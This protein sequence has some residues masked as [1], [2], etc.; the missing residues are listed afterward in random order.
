MA[1]GSAEQENNGGGGRGSGE[2]RAAARGS[3]FPQKEHIISSRNQSRTKRKLKGPSRYDNNSLMERMLVNFYCN[4][5]IVGL[6][7]SNGIKMLTLPKRSPI[8]HAG[9]ECS[10]HFLRAALDA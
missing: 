8:F 1:H 4:A 10:D 2:G 9:N 6:Q 7:E 5:T 3:P